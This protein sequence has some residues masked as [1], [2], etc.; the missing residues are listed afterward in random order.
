MSCFFGGK[1]KLLW[2]IFCRHEFQVRDNYNGNL[3][4]ILEKLQSGFSY[5]DISKA[6]NMSRLFF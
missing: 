5:F 4:K 3:A 6:D 1:F 2:K